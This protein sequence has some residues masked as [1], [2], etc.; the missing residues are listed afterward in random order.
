MVAMV[1][2]SKKILLPSTSTRCVAMQFA[3]H[4]VKICTDKRTVME[5]WNEPHAEQS[6]FTGPMTPGANEG[7][8]PVLTHVNSTAAGTMTQVDCVTDTHHTG[9]AGLLPKGIVPREEPVVFLCSARACLARN[10][11]HTEH[12]WH[13]YSLC[14]ER[15]RLYTEDAADI[16]IVMSETNP[17]TKMKFAGR[18][19]WPKW[20]SWLEV[21]RFQTPTRTRLIMLPCPLL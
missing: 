3:P 12:N 7:S 13:A 8:L 1:S 15:T 4:M 21:L 14:E 10:S 17:F 5:R 6:A 11:L 18:Q 16:S 19:G 9:G 2:D 20:A